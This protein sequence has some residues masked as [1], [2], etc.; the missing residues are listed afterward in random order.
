MTDINTRVAR[1]GETLVHL[2]FIDPDTQD[3]S[4]WIGTSVR[5]AL[6]RDADGRLVLEVMIDVDATPRGETPARVSGQ[7][8]IP[9]A[10]EAL[11]S[12]RVGGRVEITGRHDDE[13]A[14]EGLKLNGSIGVVTEIDDSPEYSIGLTVEGWVGLVWCNSSEIRHAEAAESGAGR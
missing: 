9:A 10:T 1:P 2:H 6:L 8:G 14:P 13:S 12:F 7:Q 11:R 4:T 5:R 3:R